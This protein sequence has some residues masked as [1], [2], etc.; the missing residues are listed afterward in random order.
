M[1]RAE[2]VA[3]SR[4]RQGEGPESTPVPVLRNPGRKAAADPQSQSTLPDGRNWSYVVAIQW[5]VLALILSLGSVYM[6]DLLKSTVF[7]VTTTTSGQQDDNNNLALEGQGPV[8]ASPQDHFLPE[9]IKDSFLNRIKSQAGNKRLSP[10]LEEWLT[11]NELD[12]WTPVFL[13]FGKSTD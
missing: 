5:T 3:M 12:K 6:L 1:P 7:R 2:T 13:E 4:S 10:E 9:S 11:Q 8:L